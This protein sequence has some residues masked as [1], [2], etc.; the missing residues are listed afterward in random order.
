MTSLD[1]VISLYRVRIRACFSC[2]RA[3]NYYA[4]ARLLFTRAY[5]YLLRVCAGLFHAR[6]RFD[7]RVAAAHNA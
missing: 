2:A 7:A 3:H 1:R 6:M 5:G 4:C